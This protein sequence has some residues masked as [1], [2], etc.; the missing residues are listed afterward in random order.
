MSLLLMSLLKVPG[1]RPSAWFFC[2]KG[3]ETL[4]SN[5]HAAAKKHL[6]AHACRN[7][8][9]QSTSHGRG[10]AYGKLVQGN[11]RAVRCSV[12][13]RPH[14][15]VGEWPALR[16]L[17]N[18]A[19]VHCEL[20]GADTERPDMMSVAKAARPENYFQPEDPH[21]SSANL[22]VGNSSS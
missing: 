22:T 20:E 6:S 10:T 3:A 11:Q 8:E 21:C 5:T 17:R 9:H 13:V 19:L 7:P 12:A 16:L 1:F 2:V 4:L 15:S 14:D 18:V